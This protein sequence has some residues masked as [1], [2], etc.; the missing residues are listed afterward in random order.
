MKT[1][2][3]LFSI[4][5]GGL[6]FLGVQPVAQGAEEV[7][8]GTLYPITGSVA[9][10]G[11][12]A[13]AAVKTVVDIVNNSYDLDIPLAR[14]KGLPNLGGAKIKL[15]VADHQGKPE[16]GR[17]EAE[18]LIDNEKVVA[19]FGAYHSSVSAAASNVAER[20]GIPYLT[21]ESS[22]PK[23]HTRGFKWFFRTG[24]HDGHY[25][26]T[27][28]D[29][30]RDYQKKTGIQ[31]K[32]ASIM[33]EDTQFGVDSARVQEKLC[34][35]NGIQVV[36][37]IAYRA[38]T[39]S[40]TSEVQRLK[41]ADADVFFPTSYEP[42]AI[43]T[44]KTMK[45]LGYTPKLWIAQNAG[46]NQPGFAK[47]VG[48]DAEGIIS[49][50]PFSMDMAEKIPLVGKL[51]SIYKKHSGVDIFDPP[52]RTFVGALVLI[53]AINRAGSTDPGKIRDALRSTRF[54]A[55]AIPMPWND[56]EFGSDGQNNGIST[57]LIQMQDGTY[58]SVYPFEVAA[59]QVIYPKP[60]L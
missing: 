14:T 16:I 26:K 24:P 1:T 36:A 25:T 27:M 48:K 20:R 8:I 19:L 35:E 9:L 52:I 13:L 40:L 54:P 28:F 29:F 31:I 43:L 23:L 10:A 17:A 46:Y 15:I 58:Y 51:N 22:S 59:K 45:E 37:K 32:T 50:S 56:I 12:R 7:R 30:I 53:D 3:K 2:T 57:A 49:R 60:S 41:A 44:V 33:H 42:D 47:A 6:I 18:R 21:G 4:V 34:R 11:G 39:P 38:K 5:L 55:S